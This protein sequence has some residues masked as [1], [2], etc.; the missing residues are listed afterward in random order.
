MTY[1]KCAFIVFAISFFSGCGAVTLNMA[2]NRFISPEAGAA[3]FEQGVQGVNRVTIVPDASA[4]PPVMNSPSFGGTDEGY[5]LGAGIG[6]TKSVEFYFSNDF[7]GVPLFGLKFQLLGPAYKDAKEGDFSLSLTGAWGYISQGSDNGSTWEYG[8]RVTAEDASVIVGYR[9]AHMLL[10]YGGPFSTWYEVQGSVTQPK[11]AGVSYL[12]SGKG[13]QKGINA[14]V[15]LGSVFFLRAELA[16][17]DGEY[18]SISRTK[19]DGGM[20][21]GFQW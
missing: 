16:V 11:G 20:I 13:F 7:G 18:N 21:T 6:L 12:Y 4:T 14:G 1:F 9:V 17:V 5:F 19:L 10:L 8:K 15:E 2:S 3:H